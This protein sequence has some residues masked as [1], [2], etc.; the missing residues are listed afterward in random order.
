MIFNDD[1]TLAAIGT[2]QTRKVIQEYIQEIF[3]NDR[4]I[5]LIFIAV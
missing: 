1:N 2:L 3:C 5:F 4:N